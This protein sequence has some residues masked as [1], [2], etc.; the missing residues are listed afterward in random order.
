MA[1]KEKAILYSY[2]ESSCVWRVRNVLNL[3]KIPYEIRPIVLNKSLDGG[4]QH[5]KEYLELNPMGF[6]PALIIDGVTLIES[7]NIMY[8][9]EETRPE[10]NVL[11]KDIFK[12]AKV[13]E[14]CDIIISG[15]QPL[16]NTYVLANIGKERKTEWAQFYITKGFRAIEKLLQSSAGKYCVGDDVTMADCCLVPQ[17]YNARK[18]GLDLTE[19]PTIVRVDQEL[20][21]HPAIQAGHPRAQPDYI[22]P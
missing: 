14:I 13:R 4:H 20:Q 19:F 12:R 5:S 21:D 10:V 9:L 3:K 6:V 7:H 8:Y 11:P 18:F 22:A 17:V 2:Y 15:I 1:N 16:Q